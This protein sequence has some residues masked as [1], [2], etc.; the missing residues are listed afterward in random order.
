MNDRYGQG[1]RDHHGDVFCSEYNTTQ[2]YTHPWEECQGISQSFAYNYEDNEESLGPPARL[3]HHVHRY[4]E[5]ERQSRHH[6]W[7]EASGVYPE[8]R[9]ASA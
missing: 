3:I 6:R 8:Q 7:P 5:P 9:V 1:T 2:S 4:R